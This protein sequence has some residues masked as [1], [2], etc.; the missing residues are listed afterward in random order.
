MGMLELRRTAEKRRG[1]HATEM[2]RAGNDALPELRASRR[3]QRV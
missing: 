3:N 2:R 1:A